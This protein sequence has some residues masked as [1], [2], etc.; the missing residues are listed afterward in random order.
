MHVSLLC[1][2]I[3]LDSY[4]GVGSIAE[5]CYNARK[6]S[7]SFLESCNQYPM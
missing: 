2:R 4:R 6:A 3:S 7:Q 5:L 1:M